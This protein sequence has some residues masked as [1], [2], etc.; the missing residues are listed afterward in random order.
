MTKTKKPSKRYVPAETLGVG[1]ADIGPL[2]KKYVNQALNNLRLSYGPLSVKFEKLF[3]K[4]HGVR[5]AIFCNSGTSA[6]QVALACLKEKEGWAD[7]DEVLVPAVTFVATS[8]IVLENR[9]TPVFVDV[10][11]TT[12]NID[13]DQIERHITPRTKAVI[14]VHLF[15]LPCDMDPIRSIAAKH[16]LKIIEDSCE[17]MFVRYKGKAVGSLG[18]ISCFSTYMAHFIVTGAGGLALTDNPDYAVIMKSLMN[19]GRDSIYLSIDDD[20]NKNPEELFKI[21]EGRFRFVRVGYS[22]RAT[23]MEAGL[24]LAQLER[25]KKILK[26]RQSNAAHLTRALAPVADLLQLPSIPAG[27]EHAFMMFPLVINTPR[28]KKEELVFFLEKNKIETRDMLPLVNQPVYRRLF[29]DIEDRYPN[30]KHINQN[31]FYIA[32]H[33]DLRKRDLDY[34]AETIVGFFKTKGLLKI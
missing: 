25:H 8:N 1:C 30:A 27:R 18:D 26:A 9:M 12:Y 5:F 14:P 11:R 17:T 15:G 19:H 20:K 4:L 16:R 34:M 23:E 33:Q 22:Y 2:E 32:S 31:G 24:G 29:G 13:P 28:V 10:D 21:I 3:A 6:L 7:G